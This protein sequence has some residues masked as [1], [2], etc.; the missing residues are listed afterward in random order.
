MPGGLQERLQLTC[1][2]AIPCPGSLLLKHSSHSL[3]NYRIT[4]NPFNCLHPKLAVNYDSIRPPCKSHK[5][6]LTL[7]FL[8]P[9]HINIFMLSQPQHRPPVRTAIS[10][11][12]RWSTSV[13][14]IAGGRTHPWPVCV[15]L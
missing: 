2:I 3:D 15:K 11:S 9:V 4:K 8:E 14:V 12:K 1:N 7:V 13:I 6:I 10:M 5:L